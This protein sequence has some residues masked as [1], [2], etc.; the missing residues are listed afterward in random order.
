[1]GNTPAFV[2]ALCHYGETEDAYGRWALK[3][4]Q[5]SK[6]EAMCEDNLDLCRL[7]DCHYL[8]FG[9]SNILY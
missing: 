3:L 6:S 1:M 8:I 9:P 2:K 5:Q 7:L 4:D